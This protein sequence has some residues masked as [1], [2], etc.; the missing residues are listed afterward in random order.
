MKSEEAAVHQGLPVPIESV[1]TSSY[2]EFCSSV[3][4]KRSGNV[5][6][7]AVDGI[8]DTDEQEDRRA[9]SPCVENSM[10]MQAPGC[11]CCALS[12]V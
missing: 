1:V 3:K 11:L 10:I 7:T 2:G 5:F 6:N 8:T 4:E 9:F 12:I